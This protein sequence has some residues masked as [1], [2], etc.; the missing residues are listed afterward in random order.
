MSFL[1]TSP[2]VSVSDSAWGLMRSFESGSVQ[3]AAVLGGG[4][5][6]LTQSSG[7]SLVGSGA[8]L[9]SILQGI[10][11]SVNSFGQVINASFSSLVTSIRAWT[12]IVLGG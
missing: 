12:T 10:A 3:L 7:A 2:S 8:I 9:G 11:G 4:S 5:Q 1:I 6:S